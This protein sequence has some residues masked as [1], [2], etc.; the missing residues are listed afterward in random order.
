ME[1]NAT[2][3]AAQAQ[4]GNTLRRQRKWPQAAAAYQKARDHYRTRGDAAGQAAAIACMG[5]VYWEQAQIKKSVACFE[6]AQQLLATLPENQGH[7]IVEALWGL[8]LWRQG[9]RTQALAQIGGALKAGISS[10]PEPF[11]P[12]VEAMQSAAAQ[13]ENRLTRE[14]TGGNPH[15]ALQAHLSLVPVYLCLGENKNALSHHS[16]AEALA[17]ELADPESLTALKETQSLLA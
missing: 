6:E 3:P 2:D 12:L 7:A 4:T 14:A 11:H 10:V 5:A 1:E 15:R 13:L 9:H 16:R 17:Q 8:A